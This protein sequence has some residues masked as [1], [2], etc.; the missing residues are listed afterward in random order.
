[1]N[2]FISFEEKPVGK[3]QERKDNGVRRMNKH[4]QQAARQRQAA[5]RSSMSLWTAGLFLVAVVI[6]IAGIRESAPPDFFY[7]AAI[8][9]AVLM[10]V[11]RQVSKRMKSS[12]PRSAR[13]DPKSTLKLS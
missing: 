9:M 2:P 13:P 10:L 5:L 6:F 1:V 11:I 8:A 7:K 4:E 3:G 12:G